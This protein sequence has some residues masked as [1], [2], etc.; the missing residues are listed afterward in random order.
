MRQRKVDRWNSVTCTLSS[1]ITYRTE[2]NRDGGASAEDW[3]HFVAAKDYLCEGKV[4]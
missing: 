1:I 4:E 3:Q 2:A